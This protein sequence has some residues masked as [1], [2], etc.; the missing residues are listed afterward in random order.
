MAESRR[1]DDSSRL[2]TITL[3]RIACQSVSTAQWKIAWG[4][5]SSVVRA[6]STTWMLF[7]GRVGMWLSHVASVCKAILE[8]TFYSKLIFYGGS[9]HGIRVCF[10]PSRSCEVYYQQ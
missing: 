6:L 5:F 8:P 1:E 4:C 10:N 3:W 9:F 2:E 7:D